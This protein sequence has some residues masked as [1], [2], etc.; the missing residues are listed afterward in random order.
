MPF[1][2]PVLNV[3]NMREE[4]AFFPFFAGRGSDDATMI[5]P[6]ALDFT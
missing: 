4:C 6:F 1:F 5:V 3:L 2:F